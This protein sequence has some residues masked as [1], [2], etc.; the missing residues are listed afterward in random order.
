APDA[1]V[2]VNAQGII[3]LV[4]DETTRSFGYTRGE[5]VGQPV[6]LLMPEAFRKAHPHDRSRYVAHPERRAMAPGRAFR[7]RR[8]DGSE[9]SAEISLSPLETDDGVLVI[10]AVRDVT[11]RQQA[12]KALRESEARLKGIIDAAL[13]AVITMDGSGIIRSW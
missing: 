11:E 13:D 6:E 10:A 12:D 7:A 5:L 3:V 2:I 9:F 4:N 8:K 1:M